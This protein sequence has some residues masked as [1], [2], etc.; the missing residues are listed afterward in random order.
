MLQ[1]YLKNFFS[2]IAIDIGITNTYIS[3]IEN[4]RPR[5]IEN[6]QGSRITPTYIHFSK[7]YNNENK[8]EH[9]DNILY[10]LQAKNI[11]VI[12]KDNTFYGFNMLLGR[13]YNDNFI[14]EIAVGK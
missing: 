9:N 3:V 10:G 5:I 8:P 7:S 12:N 1:C 2:T 14:K 11:S 13:K 6:T 4:N